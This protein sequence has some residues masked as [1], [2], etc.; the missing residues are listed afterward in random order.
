MDPF[1]ER[2]QAT[3]G[4]SVHARREDLHRESGR[5]GAQLSKVC[6][7]VLML[8]DLG[9]LVPQTPLGFPL[10]SSPLLCS[11]PSMSMSMSM[12]DPF[13]DHGGRM[14][15][16]WLVQPCLNLLVR[17]RSRLSMAFTPGLPLPTRAS[18][19]RENGVFDPLSPVL[20]CGAGRAGG[21]PARP[22]S[23][24]E[25]SVDDDGAAAAARLWNTVT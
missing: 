14:L 1:S 23:D 11:A 9:R 10:L 20:E 16:H 4:P 2:Q 25:L 13:S 6:T 7:S 18:P 17:I 21:T 24:R 15:A 5:T 8:N 12:G 3:L 19:P 22:D